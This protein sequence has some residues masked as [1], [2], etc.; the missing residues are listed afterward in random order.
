MKAKGLFRW[1]EGDATYMESFETSWESL[2]TGDK[3]LRN[4]FY[5]YLV[6]SGVPFINLELIESKVE[7]CGE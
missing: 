3:I 7:P 6:G 4:R 2:N 5:K 1:T